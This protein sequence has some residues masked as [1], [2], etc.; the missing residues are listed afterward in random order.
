MKCLRE[1]VKRYTDLPFLVILEPAGDGSYLYGRFLRAS[2]VPELRDKVGQYPEWKT[3]VIQKDGTLAVPYGSIGFR[4]DDSGKWNL[5]LR[6]I[7]AAGEADINPVLSVMELGS[8]EK[9]PVKFVAMDFD[10]KSLV[11]EVPAVKVGGR[12]VTTVF[13]LLAAHLGVK[14]GDL[15]GDYPTDYNDPKPF[16]PAWQ[17]SITGV[18]RDLVI[19]IARGFMDT[20]IYSRP[21]YGK[22]SDPPFFGDENTPCG[23]RAM[24]FVGPGINHWYLYP[25]PVATESRTVSVAAVYNGTHIAFLLSWSDAT[26]DVPKAG[27]L[28]VFPDAA[29]IQFPVSRAQLPYICMGTV[30]NPV[31]IIYWK[32]GVGVENMVAGAGYGLNPQQREAL[33]LQATPTSPVEPLPAP[34]QVV[35]AYAT[36]G[37]SK[38]YVILIRPLG[39]VHPLMT[40]LAEDFSVAFAVWD[41][42]R[43]ERGGLKATSGWVQFR[44]EKV[45]TPVATVTQTIAPQPTAVTQTVTT[46]VTTVVETTPTWAWAVIGVLVA[47]LAVAAGLALRRSS[48][49]S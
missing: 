16:T 18:S 9:V 47:L 7:T 39:S 36:Y 19:Q 35:Q 37:G 11:R 15:G 25:L 43:G 5:Q 4:W 12:Y 28:D 38:W 33:G 41:G 14:R 26:E 22:P 31:N 20:A 2:D 3:V 40:S 46:T 49:R 8:Y 27:G 23:G 32:A 29:A 45:A 13:D 10:I 44:L 1:Y 30:D 42:A 21:V 17:E 6:G 24:I 48:Q 34:A